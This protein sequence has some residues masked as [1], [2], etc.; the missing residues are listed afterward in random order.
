MQQL[1]LLAL[2]HVLAMDRDGNAGCPELPTKPAP[3]ETTGS[4]HRYRTELQGAGVGAEV[5]GQREV[6]VV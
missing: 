6:G 5:G 3:R 1:S 2:A 4:R